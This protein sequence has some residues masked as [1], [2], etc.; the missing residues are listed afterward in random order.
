M[1]VSYNETKGY[2]EMAIMRFDGAALANYSKATLVFTGP[3]GVQ[4]IFKLEGEKGGAAEAKY[5]GTPMS[6]EQ[7]T[8]E[9]DV[10]G[11]S[12]D[13]AV[14]FII[15]ADF[16]SSGAGIAGDITIHSLTFAA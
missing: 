4:C 11:I 15:F 13:G 8:A 10:A 3:A 7:Q 5:E 9:L 14:K 2:W 6:G 12:K 1:K 16:N